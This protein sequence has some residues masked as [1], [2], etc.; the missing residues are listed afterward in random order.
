[1]MNQDQVYQQQNLEMHQYVQA[2]LLTNGSPKIKY[3]G[4]IS[5]FQPALSRLH[6]KDCILACNSNF[7][8]LAGH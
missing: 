1:M 4:V 7:S 6:S 8:S 5:F 3:D 2:T